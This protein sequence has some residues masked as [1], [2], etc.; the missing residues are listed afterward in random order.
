MPCV[1]FD[2]CPQLAHIETGTVTS[3]WEPGL[4]YG[5]MSAPVTEKLFELCR[6]AITY[7]N[8]SST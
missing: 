4:L 5:Q 3:T 7:N 8:K 6:R 1:I 2:Q